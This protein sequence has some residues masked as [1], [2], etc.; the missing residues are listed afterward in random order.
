MAVTVFQNLL[1]FDDLDSFE[2]CWSGVLS[3]VPQLGVSDIFFKIR[4]RIWVFGRKITAIKYLSH[5]IAS[6]VFAVFLW[7]VC[8]SI[9]LFLLWQNIHICNIYHFNYF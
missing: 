4:Q 1:S 8:L 3:T 7:F 6:K 9:Y 2:E 5:D